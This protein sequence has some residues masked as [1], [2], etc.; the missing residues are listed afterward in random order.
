[1]STVVPQSA[2]ERAARAMRE[3]MRNEGW[4]ITG[5]TEQRL[6]ECTE[7]ATKAALQSLGDEWCLGWQPIETAPRDIELLLGWW[8]CWP[9]KMWESASGLAGSTKGGWL[10]GQ[11][12]HWQP[13]PR[14]PAHTQ[15]DTVKA[16]G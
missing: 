15:P 6:R 14:P 4:M 16:G 12:T 13:L 10:H 9:E 7:R 11:A 3:C 1:M 5:V 8:R 2:I